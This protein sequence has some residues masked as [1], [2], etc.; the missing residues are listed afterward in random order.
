MSDRWKFLPGRSWHLPT[1][2]QQKSRDT[3]WTSW[4]M[5]WEIW[6]EHPQPAVMLCHSCPP[7]LLLWVQPV[8]WGAVAVLSTPAWHRAALGALAWLWRA[9]GKLRLLL[10]EQLP[11]RCSEQGAGSVAERCWGPGSQVCSQAHPFPAGCVG[12]GLLEQQPRK[13]GA[14]LIFTTGYG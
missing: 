3:A 10:C 11:G 4:H 12:Q 1:W 9:L 2:Q 6:G 7:P 13:A 8:N 5:A 14:N